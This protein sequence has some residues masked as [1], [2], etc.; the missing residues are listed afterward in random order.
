M[1]FHVGQNVRYIGGR[2]AYRVTAV[3]G[4]MVTMVR[5]DG[6]DDGNATVTS[7]TNLARR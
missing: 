3:D 4:R 1:A 5:V 7:S 6:K 2:I